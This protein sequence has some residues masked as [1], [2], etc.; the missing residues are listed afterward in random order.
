MNGETTCVGVG[1][2]YFIPAN[3]EHAAKFEVETDEIEFRFQTISQQ[4][5]AT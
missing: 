2:W 5:A 4:T 1:S 3:T